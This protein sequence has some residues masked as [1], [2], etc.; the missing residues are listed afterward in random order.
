MLNIR[1][2][3][4]ELCNWAAICI[5]PVPRCH[6]PV[7]EIWKWNCKWIRWMVDVSHCV[8]GNHQS[9]TVSYFCLS[10][11][12]QLKVMQ[13]TESSMLVTPFLLYGD[14]R[15]FSLARFVVTLLKWHVFF[16][17]ETQKWPLSL[18]LQCTVFQISSE[19]RSWF[20]KKSISVPRRSV[21]LSRCVWLSLWNWG[22]NFLIKT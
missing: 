14:F 7:N 1:S 2:A 16:V 3:S 6:G 19:L 11:Y 12:S 18:H 20:P 15:T 13:L 8:M 22:S 4:A 21:L 5:N 10:E 17:R 9:S